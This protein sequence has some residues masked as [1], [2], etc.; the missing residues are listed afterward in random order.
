MPRRRDERSSWATPKA[1]FHRTLNR[2][3]S[4]APFRLITGTSGHPEAT[5]HVHHGAHPRLV[6]LGRSRQRP[7]TTRREARDT[8]AA[9]PCERRRL[10]H[11]SGAVRPCRQRSVDGSSHPAEAPSGFLEPTRPGL[12]HRP[13]A[14]LADTSIIMTGGLIV[15]LR[16]HTSTQP[17]DSPKHRAPWI[18]RP[19]ALL[20]AVAI[21][22]GI[23]ARPEQGWPKRR[24][25]ARS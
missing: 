20:S 14:R 19:T 6:T 4:S 8:H 18:E 21:A 5:D 10:T 2:L 13:L 25:K 1:S 23:G 15:N 24:Q 17:S 9:S 22:I 3:C 11:T 12:G 16:D 7:R